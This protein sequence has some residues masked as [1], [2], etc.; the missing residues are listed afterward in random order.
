MSKFRPESGKIEMI[1]RAADC[2]AVIYS[3][4][5]GSLNDVISATNIDNR[6]NSA[7]V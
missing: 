2:K 7:C 6:T 4:A 5:A 1:R 3:L